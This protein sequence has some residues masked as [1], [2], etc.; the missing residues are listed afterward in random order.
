MAFYPQKVLSVEAFLDLSLLP[1]FL[2]VC[3]FLFYSESCL[4]LS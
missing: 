2:C 4:D 3:F 1:L